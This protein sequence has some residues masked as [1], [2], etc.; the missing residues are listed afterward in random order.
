M[1][2]FRNLLLFCLALTASPAFAD[3]LYGYDATR[4]LDAVW[5][6]KH[7]TAG[8][9]SQDVSFTAG[10]HKVTGIVVHGSGKGPHPGILF[11]HWLGEPATTNHK[12]FEPD[13]MALAKKGVTSVLVDTMWAAPD[14]FETVGPDAAHDGPL[15][16]A[17]IVDMRRALD[18]LLAQKDIDATHIAYVGHD[19][20]AMFGALLASEDARPTKWVLMAAVPTMVEWYRLGKK[21]Q[22]LP[23]LAGYSAAIAKYDIMA[24]LSGLKGKAAL[25]QFATKDGYVPEAK[26]LTFIGGMPGPK[27]AIFYDADHDL[28]VPGAIADRR[29]WLAKQLAR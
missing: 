18:L 5:G 1:T 11:V 14:W 3:G 21:K 7:T 15:I 29:A 4:P 28:E 17:Q 9:V 23:D 22:A 26:A 24:G 13:A 12:E 25:F 8:V 20:G 27:T 6:A 2:Q 19:F 10:S 16:E